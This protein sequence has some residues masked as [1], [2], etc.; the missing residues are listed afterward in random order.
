M[1]GSP[2][3]LVA[4]DVDRIHEKASTL[5]ERLASGSDSL[6]GDGTLGRRRLSRW[7]HLAGED[8]PR[9]VSS[10]GVHLGL[11]EITE[12]R[13]L[14]ALG[15][16]NRTPGGTR[17]AWL[18]LLP[19]IV[20]RVARIFAS[21]DDAKRS[22]EARR[23]AGRAIPYEHLY[24][25]IAKFALDRVLNARPAEASWLNV[26]A[27]HGLMTHLVR[28]ISG[29]ASPVL[30]PEF[31]AYLATA[32]SGMMQDFFG[33]E[34]EPPADTGKAG[35][36]RNFVAARGEDGL[37]SF[38]LRFPVVARLIAETVLYWIEFASEFL[39]RLQHDRDRLDVEFNAGVPIGKL[40]FIK[41]G[42]SDPP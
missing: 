5:A 33:F 28:Q 1:A 7:K 17:P 23:G 18:C 39:T 31:L 20:E 15:P 6:A 30:H 38:F 3:R 27:R 41:A 21:G 22:S 42:V 40:R 12:D 11:G 10:L 34:E 24:W 14:T 36:Y 19:E 37:R 2:M 8:R 13:L 26:H 9:Q 4:A 16:I 25:P 29:L 32:Q 35:H